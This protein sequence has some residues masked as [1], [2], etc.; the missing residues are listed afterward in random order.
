[1]KAWLLFIV[2]IPI[3]SFAQSADALKSNIDKW[4]KEK[5]IAIRRI[6]VERDSVILDSVRR[7]ISANDFLKSTKVVIYS[8]INGA[9][10]NYLQEVQ[11]QSAVFKHSHYVNVLIKSDSSKPLS[12]SRGDKMYLK[13]EGGSILEVAAVTSAHSHNLDKR[14]ISDIIILYSLL[15]SPYNYL[16][17]AKLAAIDIVHDAGTINLPVDEA[18]AKD[19]KQIFLISK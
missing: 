1:M 11:F 13:F 12:V 3:V 17:S 14:S 6:E 9:K 8:S 4:T 10:Q 5:K 18:T 19:I 2:L 7:D 16:I 15:P